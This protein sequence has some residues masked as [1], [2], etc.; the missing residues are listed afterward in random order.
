MSFGGSIGAGALF[1]STTPPV[2]LD[3]PLHALRASSSGFNSDSSNPL[4]LHHFFAAL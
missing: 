2:N 3:A 1:A 4:T